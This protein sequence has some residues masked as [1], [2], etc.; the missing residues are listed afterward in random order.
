VI[1]EDQ[2]T[3]INHLKQVLRDE[4]VM[5]LRQVNEKLD[6]KLRQVEDYI[7]S[8]QQPLNDL[9]PLMTELVQLKI[10]E[11]RSIEPPPIN[12]PRKGKPWWAIFS[13]LLLL[14]LIPLG[15]YGYW[16]RREYLL[17]QDMAIALTATP[18]LALYR[19]GADVQGNKLYLT[20]KV[21]NETLRDRASAIAANT[22]PGLEL[23]NNIAIVNPPLNPSL[24]DDEINK[25]LN[26]LNAVNGIQV[27]HQLDGDRLTLDGSVIQKAD[28]D[29]IIAALEKING[30]NQI[31]NNIQVQS[32]SITTRLYFDQNSAAI[33]PDDV[34]QKLNRVK[35]FLQQYPNLNL[36]IIGYQHPSESANDVALKRAQSAQ[37]L[38]EDQGIDRRRIMALGINQSPPDTTADD[39][40][41][42]SRTII[43]ETPAP[44]TDAVTNDVET[45]TSP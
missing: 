10:K 16:L 41:W 9:L 34:D 43:F 4:D 15:L 45:S 39:P 30:I 1:A 22:L 28:I 5:Q 37:I 21:P 13:F 8:S 36:R 11:A 18:E 32:Q 27:T 3:R 40:I 14:I 2:A 38:L 44:T 42:L 25:I 7:A 23:N 33:K 29:T 24:I 19:L 6:F 31:T 26:S 20:G 12:P 35:E 17:E